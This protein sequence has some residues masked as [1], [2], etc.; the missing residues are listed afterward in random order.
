MACKDQGDRASAQRPL[1]GLAR[2]GASGKSLV[3]CG[4]GTASRSVWEK[5]PSLIQNIL[6]LTPL[7][8]HP[9]PGPGKV[10]RL[11]TR[12]RLVPLPYAAWFLVIVSA[13]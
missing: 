3:I 2:R 9:L 6:D 8:F 4:F 11:L 12:A 1:R 13:S 5:E 10:R 7:L